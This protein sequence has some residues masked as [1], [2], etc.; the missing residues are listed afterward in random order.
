MGVNFFIFATENH[1]FW[2]TVHFARDVLQKYKQQAPRMGEKQKK[3]TIPTQHGSEL[4]HF[5]NTPNEKSTNLKNGPLRPRGAAKIEKMSAM[6]G[7][8]QKKN[9]P[10]A[11]WEWT[12]SSLQHP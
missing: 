9:N 8:K 1:L 3:K 5:C 4:F 10:H 12:F 7:E 2:K 11:A 6:L